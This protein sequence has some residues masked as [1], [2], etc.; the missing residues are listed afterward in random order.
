MFWPIGNALMIH[1][2][3]ESAALQRVVPFELDLKEGRA[4]VSAV[5]FTLSR[6]RPRISG[7][8]AAWLLKPIA[9]HD[10]LNVRTYV[11]ANGEMGIYF[12]AEWLSNRLSVTL[13]PRAFGLP[14]RFGKI[15]YQHDWQSSSAAWQAA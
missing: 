12:L 8:I 3:V 9:T 1:F 13:G 5:A 4:F 2:E 11:G 7:R 6:M 15:A 14:Y 10:F